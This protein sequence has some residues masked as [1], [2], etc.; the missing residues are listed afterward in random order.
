MNEY[1]KMLYR[2]PS[3]GANSIHLEGASYDTTTVGS[4]DEETAALADGWFTTW[5]AARQATLDAQAAVAQAA[6]AVT[7]AAPATRAE[8]EQKAKELNI[9]FDGRTSDKKLGDLIRATLE[10]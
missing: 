9:A 2:H 1:P 10:V 4:D 7:D 5:P 3:T 6:Q 8:L